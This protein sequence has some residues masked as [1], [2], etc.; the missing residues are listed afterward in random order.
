[1]MGANGLKTWTGAL[2]V[3]VGGW[4][5][6]A[7]AC[8]GLVVGRLASRTGHVIAAHNEDN[9]APHFVRHALLPGGKNAPMFR[10]TGR[11]VLE[12]VE[13]AYA[14]FWS[15]VKS[16]RA[17]P[18]PGDL[19]F[20]E[21]GVLIYSNNGGVRFNYDGVTWKLPDDGEYSTLREGGLGH[22]LRL[23]VAQRAASAREGVSV[24]TNL[25]AR[26]GYAET[27]RIFTIADKDEAW[28][29]Q[30]VQGRRYVAR[31][32]PDREMAAYA[33]AL[34]IGKLRPDDLCSAN[35]QPKRDTL[36]FMGTYQGPRTWRV[37]FNFYRWRDIYRLAAQVDPD[38]SGACPFSVVPQRL[39]DA[40]AIKCALVSHGETITDVTPCRKHAADSTSGC[41]V[42]VCRPSTVE[43]MICLF[44]D[45]PAETTLLLA[46]GHPCETPYFAARP[47]AGILPPGAVTGDAAIRRMLEHE[48]PSKV[49]DA[50][51]VAAK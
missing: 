7:N 45:T 25:L 17:A 6:S 10:Q 3:L 22:D 30:V 27:G 28:L 12:Q 33:N 23:A 50:D 42:V 9:P 41:A 36:D 26:Y 20:N 1:M 40:E 21:K 5:I 32:C 2:A 15:E 44:G 47:F 8:T 31:R 29:V 49:R 51:V 43:S 14:C 13:N 35:M 4:C 46:T 39:I 48:K 18:N 19:F 11:A 24:M 37:P 34:T 16:E 38:V